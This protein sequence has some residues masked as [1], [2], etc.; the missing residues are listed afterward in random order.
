VSLSFCTC[1]NIL[2]SCTEKKTIFQWTYGYFSYRQ[3]VKCFEKKLKGTS[4]KAND[5]PTDSPN[6]CLKN[7]GPLSE[8][9]NHWLKLEKPH[10]LFFILRWKWNIKDA[11]QLITE[12]LP[13]KSCNL[14][15]KWKFTWETELMVELF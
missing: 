1:K 2:D 9:M 15:M 6:H 5:F 10:V 4:Q 11:P 8:P 13:Q 7:T 12:V 14:M 3:L